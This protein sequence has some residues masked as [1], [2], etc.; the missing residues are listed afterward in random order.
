MVSAWWLLLAA[1]AGVG[2]GMLLTA[3]LTMATGGNVDVEH[4]V[5]GGDAARL[6]GFDVPVGEIAEIIAMKQFVG[7]SGAARNDQQREQARDADERAI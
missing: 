5:R 4:A 6:L 7:P 2:V 1:S 3:L